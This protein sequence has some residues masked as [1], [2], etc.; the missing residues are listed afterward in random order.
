M[1][2]QFFHFASRHAEAPFDGFVT[3]PKDINQTNTEIYTP[4]TYV[5]PKNDMYHLIIYQVRYAHQGI[6][7]LTA[8]ASPPPPTHIS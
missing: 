6:L 2:T 5:G 1:L 3:G 4:L 8:F 7:S